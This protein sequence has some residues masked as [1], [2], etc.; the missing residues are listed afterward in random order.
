MA[1]KLIDEDTLTSAQG[2]W[3][4]EKVAILGAGRSGIA[5]AK[6]CLQKGISVFI[7][8]TG[9]V[10]NLEFILASNA[11]A[12]CGHEG[13]GHSARVL[14]AELIICSP[15]IPSDIP[16]LK[17]A[18]AKRIPVWAE[19]EFAF[20][21]SIAPFLAV[22]GSTGK[23][24]TV[25]LLGSVLESAG[26]AH[27]VAGNIGLPLI[28][29]APGIPAD[30]FIVAEISSFQL[31]NIDLFRPKVAAVLN[32]MKN[33]LDRYESEQAYY[34]AKKQIVKNMS[35]ADTVVLNGNDPNC[36]LWAEEL[37]GT[38][39]V[40]YFG[41]RDV[42]CRSVWCEGTRMYTNIGGDRELL[43]DLNRMKI[44]GQH[45]RENACAVAAMALEAGIA[46]GAVMEGV[47]TFT[48]L[49]HRLE[50][51]REINGV[52]YYNDSKATTA[53]SV[54]CAVNA[55]SANVHL[56]A[57]GKDKG[58]DFTAIRDSIREKVKSVS[59]IGE[60]AGRIAREWKG[61]TEITRADTLD[62]ALASIQA[63]ALP[64]DVVLLSPGCSSF[65]MF[66]SFED[67]GTIFKKLV[68][69]LNEK[70]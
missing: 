25:M 4:P 17:K 39:K 55:F 43:G 42:A 53:E 14:D 68:H 54:A 41:I 61:L 13:G 37:E 11:I 15:G 45:N 18:R 59:L 9:S 49:P 21:Q 7:S 50:F 57:G 29:V 66:A 20:R 34:N 63:R 56:I 36:R 35:S 52:A 2:A 31:E 3:L 23:S 47:C 27:T 19:V 33:H 1:Q 67:R 12:S 6:Y 38:V 62:Q 5:A 69:D 70:V 60:A 40:V 32:L 28:S 24:T 46:P 16:V 30:G 58:C 22:T 44:R 65:D 26:R 10:E 64:G 51:I 8:E 48:G